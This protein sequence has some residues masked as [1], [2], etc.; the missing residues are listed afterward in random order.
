MEYTVKN[1]KVP[2]CDGTHELSA[3]AY[4]PSGEAKGI[5]HVAHGMTEYI[6]R[7]DRFM[8]F[9]AENGYIT[10]GYDHLGH[11]Y[12]VRDDSELGF[13][14][15]KGGWELLVKDIKTFSDAVK[16]EYGETLP[17]YLMGHSMG[18]FIVRL[19]SAKYV[20]PDKLIIMGTGGPNPAAPAGLALIGLLKR[21]RGEKSYSKLLRALAFGSYNKTFGGYDENDPG[22]WLTTREEIRKKYYGDKLCTYQF[23]VSAMGD[24]IRLT[25]Y[26]N[27]G[28]WYKELNKDIPIL[29]VSGED[30]PVGNYG[31]GVNTVQKRLQKTGHSSRCILYKGVR[32][33]IL[34]DTSEDRVKKDILE[35]IEHDA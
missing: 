30:D 20:K 13:I 10:V 24:L 12:T 34:N 17:Y 14:A 21:L 6:A 27:A 35:F 22:K 5:F 7:Y 29:L 18:S 19:A 23:T 11:G 25:K 1:F 4:V 3:V 16:K 15:H 31:K 9:M 8:G 32:H 2:S 26:C 28:K 33:E